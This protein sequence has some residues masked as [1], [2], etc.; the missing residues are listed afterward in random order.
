MDDSKTEIQISKSKLILMLLGC[1][2]FVGIGIAFLIAPEK[3]KSFIMRSAT[4][5]FIAGLLGVLFFGICGFLIF[6]KLFDKSPGLIIS[7]EG[8]TDNSGAASG[9]FIPWIDIVAIKETKVVNQKVIYLVVK[10]PQAYIDK[11]KSL[12][13]K[14]MMRINQ[15]RYGGILGIS[16]NG[17]KINFTELKDILEKKFAD[18]NNKSNLT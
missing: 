18:F 14:K 6:K 9:G 3:F 1:L 5:I 7:D 10:N 2:V 13:N 17:L 8:I 15:R 11:Q 16:A 4:I 12:F